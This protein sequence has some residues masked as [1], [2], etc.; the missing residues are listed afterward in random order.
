M[1][2]FEFLIP[3]R[4]LSA[5]AKPRKLQA[6]K[7]FVRAEAAKHWTGPPA[8]G[9]LRLTLVYLCNESPPDIDNIIKPIQDALIGPV[10]TDDL[11]IADVEGHRRFIDGNFDLTRLPP[12]LLIGIAART[13]CVFV[14]VGDSML[15]EDLL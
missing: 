15:L 1:T 8:I 2:D 6:W 9:E 10:L 13:E 14:R 4:P 11:Q 5:Q 3:R 7:E 12:A